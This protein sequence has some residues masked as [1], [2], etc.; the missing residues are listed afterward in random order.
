MAKRSAISFIRQQLK[1][2]G[3]SEHSGRGFFTLY[4]HVNYTYDELNS[5]AQ[6]L[7]PKWRRRGL[8]ESFSE[9]QA[10]ATHPRSFVVV[11]VAAEFGEYYRTWRVNDNNALKNA[12]GYVVMG[13]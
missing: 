5:M 2:T 13:C 8:V 9:V 12:L 10:T 6:T 7:L 4:S 3:K 11:F 1:V